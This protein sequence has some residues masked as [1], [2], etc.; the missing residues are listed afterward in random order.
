MDNIKTTQTWKIGDCLELMQEYQDDYFDLILTDP[1]YGV[2]LEYN[3]YDDTEE[4]WYELMNKFIPEAQRVAKM[5]VFP[6]CQIKRM[7]WF[8]TNYPPDW[9]IAW[10]KGSPGTT[11][12]LGFND[13]EPMV[14][15]GKV[16]GIS[17]HDHFYCKPQRFD[18][19]HP[20]PKPIGWATWIIERATKEG[21]LVCDPF[22]GSGTMLEA[23]RITNRNCVGFEIDEEYE[24]L[25]K[26][27]LDKY[28]MALSNWG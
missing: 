16:K 17:M 8:Y 25:Y 19:G 28:G 14:V 1:P 27:R 5:V 15:Y 20:C 18:I 4:N 7:K 21:N 26:E 11:G 23:C 22:L 12:Y 24:H 2:N 6:S 3:L 10:Y 9:L 13:W